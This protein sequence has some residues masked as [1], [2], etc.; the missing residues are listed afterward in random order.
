M[1]PLA[2]ITLL[3][4][5]ILYLTNEVSSVRRYYA[6]EKLELI[7]MCLKSNVSP[8]GLTIMMTD[9]LNFIDDASEAP[10]R[11]VGIYRLTT[12]GRLVRIIRNESSSEFTSNFNYI[13]D[14]IMENDYGVFTRVRRFGAIGL[15]RFYVNY[16]W[17]D[18]IAYNERVLLLYIVDLDL[19][20]NFNMFYI[21]IYIAIILVI[22]HHFYHMKTKK[23][24]MMD[25]LKEMKN[26]SNTKG[27][28]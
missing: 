28:S 25:V 23:Y 27:N 14:D 10:S 5:T 15:H 21:I 12:N 19:I 1:F 16:R 3:L 11:T 6:T 17:I 2:I 7:E 4:I 26:T 9:V 22:F 8:E 20:W 13:L 18:S 24:F